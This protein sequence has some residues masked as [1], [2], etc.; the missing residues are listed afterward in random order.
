MRTREADLRQS[1][2][3]VF[4]LISLCEITCMFPID[5]VTLQ[6]LLL[7][8]PSVEL[9]SL[10]GSWPPYSEICMHEFAWKNVYH[11]TPYVS[12]CQQ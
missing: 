6:Y 9:N 10:S 3:H 11:M 8:V 7:Y 4:Q 12:A 1:E 5:F 2:F